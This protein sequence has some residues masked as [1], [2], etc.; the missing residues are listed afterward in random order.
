MAVDSRVMT[1]LNG[2][3]TDFTAMLSHANRMNSRDLLDPSGVRAFLGFDP[4]A[5][6]EMTREEFVLTEQ[7]YS[8]VFLTLLRSGRQ[9][10]EQNYQVEGVDVPYRELLNEAVVKRLGT[11]YME[12][13]LDPWGERYRVWP[14]PWPDGED[15][16][17]IP[18]RIY[19][20]TQTGE[21]T[22]ML[23]E[24]PANRNLPIYLFS[25]GKDKTSGQGPFGDPTKTIDN[26]SRAAILWNGGDDINNWD[27]D[28][29]WR[30]F[31]RGKKWSCVGM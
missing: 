31:Y 8:R 21:T 10:L 13:R 2:M 23:V 16:P 17:P 1:E 11:S 27:R 9:T 22:G 24:I 12:V 26:T 30:V 5:N 14:D 3:E 7:F 25:R 15:A 28:Q 19:W 18:F 6:S 4:V 20:A 29:G